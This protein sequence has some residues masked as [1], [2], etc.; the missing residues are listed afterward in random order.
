MIPFVAG[1]V[2]SLLTLIPSNKVGVAAWCT[3][4]NKT[5]ECNYETKEDCETY[6]QTDERCV[7]NPEPGRK[8]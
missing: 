3:V 6:R 8:Y 7:P 5:V 2:G 4:S 1:I